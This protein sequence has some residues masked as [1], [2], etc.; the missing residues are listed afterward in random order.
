[1][2]AEMVSNYMMGDEQRNSYE[3]RIYRKKVFDRLIE[4]AKVTDKEVERDAL[5]EEAEETSE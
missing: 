5:N 2:P 1:M 3:E 4:T